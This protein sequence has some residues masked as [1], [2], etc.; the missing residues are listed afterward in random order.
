MQMSEKII[1]TAKKIIK[2]LIKIIL[3]PFNILFSLLY[4]IFGRPI[5]RRFKKIKIKIIEKT[6]P[7]QNINKIKKSARQKCKSIKNIQ[8]KKKKEKLKNEKKV[9]F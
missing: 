7:A 2:I 1:N 3:T 4:R 6:Q 9:N 5:L 8:I